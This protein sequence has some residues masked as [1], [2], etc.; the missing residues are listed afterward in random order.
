MYLKPVTLLSI[1][2]GILA[3]GCLILGI[4]LIDRNNQYAVGYETG[5]YDAFSQSS[6][7]AGYI[8]GWQD[9]RHEILYGD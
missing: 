9:A 3:I 1:A 4:L 2:C 7:E 5:W 6:Y 8:E